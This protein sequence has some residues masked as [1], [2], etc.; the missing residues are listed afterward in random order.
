M[1]IKF[2]VFM[3]CDSRGV[4][5]IKRRSLDFEGKLR[6][7]RR[8]WGGV[9]SV[10]SLLS[11]GRGNP[12]PRCAMPWINDVEG[13]QVVLHAMVIKFCNYGMWFSSFS[14]VCIQ[15]RSLSDRL[16]CFELFGQV[17]LFPV[18]LYMDFKLSLKMFISCFSSCVYGYYSLRSK[19]VEATS[20][21]N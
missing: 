2:S 19:L 10:L 4:T 14:V 7:G 6:G 18:K 15:R 11:L 12:W 3:E 21:S 5:C 17:D 16:F 8:R 1:V 9:I 13:K 20:L